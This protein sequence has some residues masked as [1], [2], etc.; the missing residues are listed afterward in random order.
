MTCILLP[1]GRAINNLMNQ[2]PEQVHKSFV[3]AFNR[4]DLETIA[5]L[6]EPNAVLV[7]LAGPVSGAEAIREAYRGFFAMRP[8]IEVQ[9]LGAHRA[10]DLALL[11][12][13]WIL[14][15]TGPDGAEVRREGHNTEAVRRQPDGRWLFAIDNPDTP[16]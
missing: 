1:V 6:Y 16:E 12:G 4:H 10:G 13:R 3:E 5:A 9:T 8:T 14:R 7:S 2:K 11:H 15:G